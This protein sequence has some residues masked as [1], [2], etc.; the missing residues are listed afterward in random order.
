MHHQDAGTRAFDGIVLGDEA[1]ERRVA[2]FKFDGLGVNAGA[3]R[4]GASQNESSQD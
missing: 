4:R 3:R 1:F 2:L